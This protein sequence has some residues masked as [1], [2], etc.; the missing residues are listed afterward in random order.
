MVASALRPARPAPPPR[1][2]RKR[3]RHLHTAG[4]WHITCK[5]AAS[6]TSLGGPCDRPQTNDHRSGL[7]RDHRRRGRLSLFHPTRSGVSPTARTGTRGHGARDR[8]IPRR[9]YTGLIGGRSRVANTTRRDERSTLRS[10]PADDPVL[11]GAMGDEAPRRR[12]ARPRRP[13]GAGFILGFLTG[14]VLGAGLGILFA[15]KSGAQLRRQISSQ[16]SGVAPPAA[17]RLGDDRPP[18]VEAIG[19]AIPQADA[20]HQQFDRLDEERQS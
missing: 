16:A 10:A 6:E 7:R 2:P 9:A 4:P 15:P 3:P 19:D 12:P 20:C 14:G 8:P 5:Q 18:R 11:G 1:L 17:R 13:G